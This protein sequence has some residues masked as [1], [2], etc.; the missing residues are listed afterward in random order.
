M[1]SA[2]TVDGVRVEFEALWPRRQ[3]IEIA[4]GVVVA[5]PSIADLIATKRFA[6]RSKDAEDVR[7]LEVLRSERGDSAGTSDD[8]G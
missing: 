8:S 2:S 4:P 1:R 5:L 7:L 6:A 3:S